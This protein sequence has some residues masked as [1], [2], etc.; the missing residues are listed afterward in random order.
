MKTIEFK[1]LRSVKQECRKLK[2]LPF[3][4][5]DKMRTVILTAPDEHT[6][7]L[8]EKLEKEKHRWSL[9]KF[10]LPDIWFVSTAEDLV[11]I[12]P[13]GVYYMI[14]DFQDTELERL[15]RL[16]IQSRMGLDFSAKGFKENN[17][18]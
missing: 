9:R 15:L 7:A 18:K 12:N 17:T 4:S 5:L 11:G 3:I 8:L 6:H 10:H 1:F 16:R 14:Q 2:K 13:L